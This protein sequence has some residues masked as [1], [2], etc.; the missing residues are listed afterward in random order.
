MLTSSLAISVKCKQRGVG[1][2]GNFNVLMT[3]FS[4]DA[5]TMIARWMYSCP[6]IVRY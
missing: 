4:A 6:D 5:G 1:I 2:I 3:S